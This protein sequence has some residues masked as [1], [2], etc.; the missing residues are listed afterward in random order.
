MWDM[1]GKLGTLLAVMCTDEGMGDGTVTETQYKKKIEKKIKIVALVISQHG[2]LGLTLE[3]KQQLLLPLNLSFGDRAEC[4]PQSPR[5]HQLLQLLQDIQ[6]G[7][8]GSHFLRPH[9]QR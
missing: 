1:G 6:S 7:D 3:D 4:T 9:S 5:S 8:A 2:G